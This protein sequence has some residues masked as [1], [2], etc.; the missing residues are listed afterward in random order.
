MCTAKG[1]I[2]G[3]A[4]GTLFVVAGEGRAATPDLA[5][6]DHSEWADIVLVDD[7]R[8]NA[9]SEVENGTVHA[10]KEVYIGL[11]YANQGTSGTNGSFL[12]ELLDDTE[13]TT[14]YRKTAEPLD[15]GWI[16]RSY[17]IPW[18]F[19]QPGWHTLRLKV[20]GSNQVTESDEQNNQYT[21]TVYVNDGGFCEA[22]LVP[23]QPAEWSDVLLVAD[24]HFNESE[25]VIDGTVYANEEAYI[26]FAYKNDSTVSIE[27][28]F[29]VTIYD[30]TE[31][32][33]GVITVDPPLEGGFINLHWNV[34]WTF[35]QAGWHDLRI[36]V[37][38]QSDIAESDEENNEYVR[39]FYVRNS[40]FAFEDTCRT[41][42]IDATIWTQVQGASADSAAMNEPTGEYSLRLGGSSPSGEHVTSAPVDLSPYPW[43]ALVYW[44][45]RTGSGD[46]PESGDDL[47]V[48]YYNG[49]GWV[50]LD[51]QSGGGPDMTAFERVAID[52]P[53]GA[54]TSGFRLRFRNTSTMS[55]FDDWFLDDVRVEVPSI[56][57]EDVF[58]SP[59][60][61]STLWTS[62]SGATI[63]AVGT[64]EPSPD[65]SLRL[66]GNPSGNDFAESR[67]IDL[68][69][70]SWATL[71][72]YYERRGGGESPDSGDDLIVEYHNGL[73]W[74]ELDRRLGEGPDM[75]D[76]A[77]AVVELPPDAM[78]PGFKLR[79]RN[80]A[81]AGNYDDWFVD[82][83]RIA[84]PHGL[85]S[86][87][88]PST[89]IDDER[90][91]DVSN[92]TVDGVGLSEPS[93]DYSLRLNGNPGGGDSIIS[94][95]IDLSPYA[96]ATLQYF[97]ERTGGGE[98]PD[99]GDDLHIEYYNGT[100][101]IPLDRQ[102]GSGPD[103]QDYSISVI[104]LPA[105]AMVSDFR[106]HIFNVGA[107]GS[108]DDWFVDDIKIEQC[109][110]P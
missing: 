50:E 6:Y 79:L 108:Y 96:R 4:L 72:Y 38:S 19:T 102:L 78:S 9:A 56:V 57:F 25:D 16:V 99:S 93:P 34:A 28:S 44:Y 32:S 109:R 39:S 29:K 52:L 17:N 64:G 70:Y 8:S 75:T 5:P 76:Y 33:S 86:D 37:D 49:A 83:V 71:V 47:V 30:D 60:F 94:A 43:A 110:R 97:Y 66:N 81:S 10:C 68:A 105:D 35:R 63:D 55:G 13:G 85:F 95:A 11:C 12:V 20:D 90:W 23:H 3:C 36:R 87:E 42:T 84:V 7:Q 104:E 48:E 107:S 73:G 92:A 103:M 40:A 77:R 59:T 31:G 89:I 18:T 2:V 82:D 51:R 58:A 54:M 45:E 65:F 80:L 14:I 106:L 46:S 1:I 41:N 15:D 62:F 21:R 24:R 101:W 69:P 53:Q 100:N 91:A 22:D 61:D 27:R 98:S 26:A 88:F 74:V 67:V